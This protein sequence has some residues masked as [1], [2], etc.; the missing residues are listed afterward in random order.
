MSA[1]QET[2]HFIGG[3]GRSGTTLVVD[4]LGLHSRLSPIYETEFV[5]PFL[6][7]VEAGDLEKLKQALQYSIDWAKPL[8][9][10]PHNKREHERYHHGPHYVLFTKKHM[11]ESVRAFVENLDPSNIAEKVDRLVRDLFRVHCDLDGKEL[12]INKTPVYVV[13]L[14]GL[15]RVFSKMK[16]IHCIRDGRDV[17]CSMTTR[18][19]GPDNFLDIAKIW[20]NQIALARE[21]AGA[22]PSDYMEFRYEDLVLDPRPCLEKLFEFLGVEDESAALLE[23]YAAHKD[24]IS[25]TKSPLGN[26]KSKFS[27]EE[28]SEFWRLAGDTLA[29]LGYPKD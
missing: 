29:E 22:H 17:A 28:K 7:S 12:W 4:M 24:G 25:L 1:S 15:K 9:H 13:H 26:W 23:T 14:P 20:K 16:F 18:S 10:R 6:E 21:F 11:G 27:G 19:W 3:V 5:T 2:A 8:P